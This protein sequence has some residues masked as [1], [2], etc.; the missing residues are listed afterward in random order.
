MYDLVCLRAIVRKLN[1]MIYSNTTY[2]FWH[3]PEQRISNF[4][5]ALYYEA[6]REQAYQ[7]IDELCNIP[8]YDDNDD[9]FDTDESDE[10][11]S[12]QHSS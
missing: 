4:R 5:K 3:T 7:A 1:G 8:Q 10:K 6:L 12:D 11:D 9:N 2:I